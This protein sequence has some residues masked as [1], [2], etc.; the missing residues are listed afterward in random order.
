M[1]IISL[2]TD[3]GLKDPYVAQMKAAILSIN[4]NICLVDISHQVTKF[5]IPMGAY[6]LACAAPYFPSK[7]IHVVVV[8]PGV[9]T[10]RRPIIV[11][12]KLN[13]Y[14]GP[15]NGVL[16]LAAQK[17]KITHVYSIKNPD[18]LLS[19]VSNTFH[20]RDIFAPTAAHLTKGV[21]ACE[22]GPEIHDYILPNFAKPQTTNSKIVGEV[23]HIDN[24]GNLISNI[25]VQHLEEAKI[26]TGT[27]IH[28]DVGGHSLD[29]PFCLAYGEVYL[30]DSLVLVG[31]SGFVELAVN[32]GSAA[33]L[34][35]ATVGDMFCLYAMN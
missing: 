11:E 12:T 30:G 2:L 26:L 4:P 27:T 7:T 22:F 34:F 31:S 20:G 13:F 6:C 9:G 17:E 18:Y 28:A 25:S 8:D 5:S 29:L 3:F 1:S 19:K 24:F 32:R 23:L 10:K 15:D 35:G 16:M 21:K 14:V 33:K